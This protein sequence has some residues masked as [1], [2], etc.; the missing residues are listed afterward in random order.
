MAAQ[1]TAYREDIGPAAFPDPPAGPFSCECRVLG[2]VHEVT[3]SAR[4]YV[5]RPQ[6]MP[7]HDV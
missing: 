3:L 6:P 2:C 7:T 1:L 5:L 4:D